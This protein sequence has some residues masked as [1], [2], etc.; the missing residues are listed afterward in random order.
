MEVTGYNIVV[1]LKNDNS[2]A[3]KY[4]FRTFYLDLYNRAFKYTGKKEDAKDLVQ[5]TFI[6]LWEKRKELIDNKPIEPLLYT[7]HRNNCLDYVKLR[8]KMTGYLPGDPAIDT[9]MD[10]PYDQYISKELESKI[11]RAVSELP[12][13]CRQIFEHSRYNDLKYA[14]IAAKLNISVKT[15]ENQISIALEKL[16]NNLID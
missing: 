7:I 4:M 5:S 8:K 11:N 14:E 12:S 3:Y 10:T 1:Q 9:D 15:V 6:K 16:R 2:D 13:K